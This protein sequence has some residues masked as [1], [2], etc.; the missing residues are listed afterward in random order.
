MT[1]ISLN[2]LCWCLLRL[3]TFNVADGFYVPREEHFLRGQLSYC[4]A[5]RFPKLRYLASEQCLSKSTN[6]ER[7]H[8]FGPAN[9]RV[10]K[11]FH[12]DKDI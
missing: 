1:Q 6:K 8:S 10:I 11:E 9:E 3:L 5:N 2:E 4:A 7:C 12:R